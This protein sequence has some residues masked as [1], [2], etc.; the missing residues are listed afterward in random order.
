MNKICS[1]ISQMPDPPSSAT[2]ELKKINFRIWAILWAIFPPIIIFALIW[3]TLR[4]T[5]KGKE[6]DGIFYILWILGLICLGDILQV[7]FGSIGTIAEAL[8]QPEVCRSILIANGFATIVC[9]FLIVFT[10]RK[11]FPTSYL[12]IN[13]FKIDKTLS[14]LWL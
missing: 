5:I 13:K 10:F 14:I 3:A 1:G 4:P 11:K 6:P 2:N 12:P 9:I 7:P 8:K